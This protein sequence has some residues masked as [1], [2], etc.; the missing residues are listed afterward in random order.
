MMTPEEK[1]FAIKFTE[2]EIWR[3]MEI[4]GYAESGIDN[5]IYNAENG[6]GDE[7]KSYALKND[8]DE[9]KSKLYSYVNIHAK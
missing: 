9:L 7:D 1:E 2:K 4:L 3:A 6:H 5:K 8:W